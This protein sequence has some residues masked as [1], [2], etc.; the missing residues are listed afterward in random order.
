MNE[1]QLKSLNEI[2]LNLLACK[3]AMSSCL[4]SNIDCLYFRNN[5]YVAVEKID[6]AINE[7]KELKRTTKT[8][9]EEVNAIK[10]GRKE[11]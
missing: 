10:E 7:I 9:E 8:K 2:L 6:G 11:D 1:T 3:Q 5:N 4:C